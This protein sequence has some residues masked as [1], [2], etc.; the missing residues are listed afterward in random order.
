MRLIFMICNLEHDISAF[1]QEFDFIGGDFADRA[2]ALQFLKVF[3]ISLSIP[4]QNT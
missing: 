4:S 1:E 3:S 2:Q